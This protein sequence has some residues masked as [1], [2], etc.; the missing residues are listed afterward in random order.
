MV[1]IACIPWTETPNK[2][3]FG[4]IKNTRDIR[5]VAS[6][7]VQCLHG[8]LLR[9]PADNVIFGYSSLLHKMA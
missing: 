4:S 7:G 6:T 3:R 2:T 1:K 5:R 9:Y 8:L